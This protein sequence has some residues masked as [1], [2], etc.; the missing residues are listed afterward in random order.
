MQ[1]CMPSRVYKSA[2]GSGTNVSC[3]Q[4]L[5]QQVACGHQK[6]TNGCSCYMVTVAAFVDEHRFVSL[7]LRPLC[8]G[9]MMLGG[10]AANLHGA[11]VYNVQHMLDACRTKR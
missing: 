7:A 4:S 8:S 10:A 2:A 9:C 1:C 11:A 3:L 6:H 5:W